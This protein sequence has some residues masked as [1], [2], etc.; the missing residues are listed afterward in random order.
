MNVLGAKPAPPQKVN[1]VLDM[2]QVAEIVGRGPV[3]TVNQ[4][5]MNDA[6]GWFSEARQRENAEGK[7][8]N[9]ETEPKVTNLLEE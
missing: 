4:E 9:Q 2:V 6:W 8:L 5:G 7:K 1:H 3:A